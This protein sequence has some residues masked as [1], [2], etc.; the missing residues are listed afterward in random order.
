GHMAF[1]SSGRG[2]C[3][4]LQKSQIQSHPPMTGCI[5]VTLAQQGPDLD[6]GHPMA[7]LLVTHGGLNSLMESIYH[8]VPVVGIPL[9]GDQHDNMVRVEAKNMGIT[10]RIDQLKADKFTRTMKQVIE[11]KRYKSAVMSLST[12]HHSHPLP[13]DQ[14]LGRWIEHVLQAR[15]GAHLQPYAFQQSWYQQYLLDVLLFLSGS[16][17]GIIYLCVK[18]VR[19]AV[20]RIRSAGKQKQT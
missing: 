16:V 7:R 13:P 15:G 3:T 20:F 11:D 4:K 10:L 17:L 2:S 5:S 12:I 9:F 6:W 14:R 8:G 18:L 1:S 19:T